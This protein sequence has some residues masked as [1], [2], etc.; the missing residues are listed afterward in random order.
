MASV[1]NL[2]L[3]HNILRI[4]PQTDYLSGKTVVD[5]EN[6]YILICIYTFILFR[7]W[8]NLRSNLSAHHMCLISRLGSLLVPIKRCCRC[9]L[10]R[11]VFREL[12]AVFFT[13]Y[14]RSSKNSVVRR[15]AMGQTDLITEWRQ[16]TRSVIVMCCW[17]LKLFSGYSRNSN[18]M[19]SFP[20]TK[21]LMTGSTNKP[22]NCRQWWPT[23]RSSSLV[24]LV[25]FYPFIADFITMSNILAH[26]VLADSDALESLINM[27][28]IIDSIWTRS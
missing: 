13:N 8:F 20:S 22:S 6:T 19:N 1:R 10:W 9:D 2:R 25:V 28:K 23:F 12:T 21:L 5:E 16:V 14:N 4:A 27:T 3:I 11:I 7:K 18:Q 26:G 17:S 15:N 24:S